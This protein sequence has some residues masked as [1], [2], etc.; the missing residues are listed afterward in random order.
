MEV[1]DI[2]DW[3]LGRCRII[4]KEIQNGKI[5]Y[6]LEHLIYP[7]L[8][9]KVSEEHLIIANIKTESLFNDRSIPSILIVDDFYE[10][11]DLIRAIALEQEFYPNIKAYK[12]LRSSTRFLLPGLKEK[13][14]TLLG[15]KI[16]NWLHYPTNGIFQITKYT[17]P[18]V[19]H[20]DSQ[21][22]AAAIYLTPS[23][24]V[25]AGT[26]FWKDGKYGCR[27]PPQHPKEI[28]R[29]P[30]VSTRD[31]A[32]Q[33]IYSE[34]NLVN[35]DGKNWELVDKVGSVFNRLVIWDAQLIHSASSYQAFSGEQKDD[36]RLVQLFFFD[37]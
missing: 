21:S 25:S 15:V 35:N 31:K 12:G 1:N 20:S 8:T 23:A 16:S 17:D 18:L 14:E 2:V 37:I 11:P 30:D 27:R 36:T 34:Y 3:Y 24:P 33:E 6:S 22:Y 9:C 7:A 10:N 13:F 5:Y 19:Y 28:H 4:S 29:F 32:G 26:S